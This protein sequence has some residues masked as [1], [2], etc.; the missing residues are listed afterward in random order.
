MRENGPFPPLTRLQV[1]YKAGQ[2]GA[3]GDSAHTHACQARFVGLVTVYKAKLCLQEKLNFLYTGIYFENEFTPHIFSRKKQ[4]QTMWL[5]PKSTW[6]NVRH[7]MSIS[8]QQCFIKGNQSRSPSVLKE[9]LQLLPEA[10]QA[11]E[12]KNTSFATVFKM[13]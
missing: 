13:L 10:F 1:R 3:Q 9:L 8:K 6:F 7:A 5:Y 11:Y 4:K 12:P 2:A